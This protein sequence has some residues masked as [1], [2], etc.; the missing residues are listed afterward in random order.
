M[1][2]A[3]QQQQQDPDAVLGRFD[4][5]AEVAAEHA[6]WAED[7]SRLATATAEA[8]TEEAV[9]ELDGSPRAAFD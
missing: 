1:S 9:A 4:A 8:L 3:R 5:A 6:D 7:N 2:A